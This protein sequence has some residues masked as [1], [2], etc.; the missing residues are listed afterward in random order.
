MQSLLTNPSLMDCRRLY[1]RDYEV[2]INI[3][4]H[5]FEKKGEMLGLVANAQLVW[6]FVDGPALLGANFAQGVGPNADFLLQTAD[7]TWG[8]VGVAGVIGNGPLQFTVGFDTTIGRTN[9][10]AQVIRGSA[11]YRF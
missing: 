11:T 4:V 7:H 1:L 2:W 9:A 6:E 5:D 8:E 10:D 3:G